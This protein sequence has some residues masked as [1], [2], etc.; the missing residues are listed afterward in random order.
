MTFM[1]SWYNGILSPFEIIKKKYPYQ[2][3]HIRKN[4]NRPR[5]PG[6]G[7]NFNTLC[8]ELGVSGFEPPTSASQT[9]RAKPDCATPRLFEV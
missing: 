5:F 3:N 6:G 4:Q 2:F 1:M 8:Q 7:F 9:L